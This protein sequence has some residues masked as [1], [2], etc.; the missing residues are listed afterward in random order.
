MFA[1]LDNEKF[2]VKAYKFNA[3]KRPAEMKTDDAQ[4]YLAVKSGSWKPW[5][6]IKKLQSV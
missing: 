1:V 5:W 4:F 2:S 3:E 6:K